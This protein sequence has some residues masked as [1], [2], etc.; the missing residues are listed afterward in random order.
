VPTRR[1]DDAAGRADCHSGSH[2]PAHDLA[3]V[4]SALEG[5]DHDIAIVLRKLGECGPV[6]PSDCHS[7]VLPVHVCVAGAF[8]PFF[9]PWRHFF[10]S[11]V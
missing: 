4:G 1:A 2:Q 3:A 9:R 6:G 8:A 7:A 11:S 5:S 10:V